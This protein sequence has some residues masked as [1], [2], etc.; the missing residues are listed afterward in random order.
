MLEGDTLWLETVEVKIT[1]IFGG[2]WMGVSSNG[3][4]YRG[5]TV[6]VELS[7]ACV[8]STSYWIKRL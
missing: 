7:D 3:D 1:E 5:L 6:F 4:C 2:Q 8:F